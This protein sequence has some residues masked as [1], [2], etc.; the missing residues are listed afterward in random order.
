MHAAPQVYVAQDLPPGWVVAVE[1]EEVN[2]PARRH[3]D[4]LLLHRD[5]PSRWEV[6]RNVDLRGRVH[7]GS[8]ASRALDLAVRELRSRLPGE[9]GSE[10]I[11]SAARRSPLTPDQGELRR[12]ASKL[13]ARRRAR[14]VDGV[15]F[16]GDF[17]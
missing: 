11:P 5:D 1:E 10:A 17:E 12:L 2:V 8:S 7:R 13:A 6:L 15:R 16:A 14:A 3:V 9:L 4:L